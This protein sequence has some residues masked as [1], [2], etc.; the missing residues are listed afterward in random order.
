M[1]IYIKKVS[2]YWMIYFFFNGKSVRM[3]AHYFSLISRYH[4]LTLHYYLPEG[5]SKTRRKRTFSLK[6][7]PRSQK[8]VF[9]SICKWQKIW[10]ELRSALIY[11]ILFIYK[12]VF[13]SSCRQSDRGSERT[14][15]SLPGRWLGRMVSTLHSFSLQLQRH[16][17]RVLDCVLLLS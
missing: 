11:I 5:F 4:L 3:F 1:N 2:Y 6:N 12:R 9:G 17:D 8:S 15:L 14:E 10:K 16:C 7:W 13:S